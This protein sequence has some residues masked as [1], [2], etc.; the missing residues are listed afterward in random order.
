MSALSIVVCLLFAAPVHAAPLPP[1]P[2]VE[3]PS[4]PSLPPVERALIDGTLQ[5]AAVQRSDQPYVA[6]DLHFPVPAGAVSELELGLPSL[7][8]GWMLWGAEHMIL[9]EDLHRFLKE[10]TDFDIRATPQGV[11][12]SFSV[13]ASRLR[14]ALRTLAAYLTAPRFPEDGMEGYRLRLRTAVEGIWAGPQLTARRS[15]L[16]HA[17]GDHPMARRIAGIHPPID[18]EIGAR[19]AEAFHAGWLGRQQ[20]QL[21][22]VGDLDLDRLT[23]QLRGA[24]HTWD[25]SSEPK[26]KAVVPPSH[27][28]ALVVLP[29]SGLEQAPLSVAW[30][31]DLPADAAAVHLLSTILSDGLPS[32][33]NRTLREEL[34]ATYGVSG[35]VLES[36]DVVA[37]VID[38]SIDQDRLHEGFALLEAQ[39]QDLVDAPV[40]QTEL[41]RAR[42]VYVGGALSEVA[43]LSGSAGFWSRHWRGGRAPEDVEAWLGSL[44]DVTPERLQAAAVALFRDGRRGAV[45]S[46]DVRAIG[47]R[48][49]VPTEPAPGSESS[50]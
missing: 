8:L 48:A 49:N 47:D 42:S 21:L 40:D 1:A 28:P 29:T 22:L 45:A 39:V 16:Q 20:A 25:E 23:G 32:R 43:S 24:F 9:G 6:V 13:P 7:T 3:P 33:M 15:A 35:R 11:G 12:Y 26:R 50:P 17:L 10:V 27:P 14:P 36:D 18:A 31:Q 4:A 19:E 30:A 46:G 44:F 37:L 38:A 2:A 41:D 5:V 34:G